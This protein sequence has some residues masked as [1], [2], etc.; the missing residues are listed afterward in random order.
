MTN[1]SHRE[2]AL[3]HLGAVQ[4]AVHAL[5]DEYARPHHDRAA[6]ADLQA[7]IGRGLKIAEVHATLAV[8]ERLD[9][10]ANGVDAVADLLANSRAKNPTAV[11]MAITSWEKT[12]NRAARTAPARAAAERRFLDLADGDPVLADQLRREHFQRMA[13]ARKNNK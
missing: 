11:E 2:T 6:V 8:A 12:P 10:I 7:D 9:V 1:S 3:D 13:E 5:R 4:A